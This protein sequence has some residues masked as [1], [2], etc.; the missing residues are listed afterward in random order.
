MPRVH[1]DN[2]PALFGQSVASQEAIEYKV[3]HN[4]KINVVLNVAEE[5]TSEMSHTR[6]HILYLYIW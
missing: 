6:G 2:Y 4:N 1:C 5:A 3:G